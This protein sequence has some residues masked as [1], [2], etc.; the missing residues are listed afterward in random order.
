MPFGRS[1]EN[2]EDK[3]Y[4]DGDD[5]YDDTFKRLQQLNNFLNS[6]SL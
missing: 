2:V 1:I 4:V 6:N 3:V 5:D